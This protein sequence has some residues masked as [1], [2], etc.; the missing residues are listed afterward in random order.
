[1][2]RNNKIIHLLVVMCVIFFSLMAYLTYFQLFTGKKIESSPYNRRQQLKE[3]NTK[4][5]SIFDRNGVILAQSNNVKG[6]WERFYPYKDLYSH[7][8]G[9]NSE[10]YGRTLLE[11][12][13]NKYLLNINEVSA[14]LGLNGNP[15]NSK[16]E[17]NNIYLTID[18]KL[19]KLAS[20]LLGTKKGAVVAMNPKTGGILAMVSKPG[21]DTNNNWLVKNWKT[22]VE[23]EES[24]FL[25][26]ATQGLYAPGSTFKV[27]VAASALEK[28]LG[29][30]IF[31]DKGTIN[32]D[33]KNFSNSKKKANGRINLEKAL[34]V[35]SNVAFSELG[36]KLGENALKEMALKIR[37][38]QNIPFDIPVKNSV[39][40]YK[41]MGKTDMAAISIGQG[42][43]LVTPLHMAMIASCIA[44]E[45]VMMKPI[46]VT[47]VVDTDGKEIKKW[48]PQKLQTSMTADTA[49]KVKN[50]M[51][52][53][54]QEGTG[55]SASINGIKVAG[56]TGT[57]ENELTGKGENKE[58]A[59]FIGFAPAEN[60][61]IAV[62][63]IV[64]YGGGSGGTVSAPIAGKLMESY[65]NSTKNTH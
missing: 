47:R 11:E 27:A 37:M 17:G 59:W 38:E 4:R 24:P 54:V 16:K 3:D 63:V 8:I 55:R 9:Y 15:L 64:E 45:G 6:K 43:M 20:D 28:G 40:P 53:V 36:V 13:Y 31:D 39:F 60:P 50:M 44:N 58:H 18:H 42:K 33:G 14:V 25:P 10:V 48:G 57:A 26:R 56:K 12:K 46:L 19:Q 49:E 32:I 52:K 34:T 2:Q 29:D 51:V 5:G 62:A 65:L 22:L 21:F 7:V 35:S 61:Q 41:S 23:S 1:M 30:I